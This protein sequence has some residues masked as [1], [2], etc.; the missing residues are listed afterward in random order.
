MLEKL[1]HFIVHKGRH[2]ERFFVAAVIVCAVCYPFVGVNYDLSKYLPDFAPTKQALDVMEEEFGYPGMARIMIKDVTLPE[3]R[4]IRQ[5]IA[6][7]DGVDLI[8]GPDMATNVYAMDSFTENALSDKFYKDGNAVY[9]IIFEDGDADERTHEAIRQIY[10][11]V[12]KDRGCFSGSAVSS[13]ERQ[14]SIS[15]EITMAIGMA[16]VIIWL[17]LTLKI[18]RAH[19]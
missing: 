3:A 7:V 10:D 13:K 15:R 14:E 17:I 18:G 1:A 16:V 9:Q 19:V 5:K 8:V 4:T 12:G 11:I 6:D 2:I